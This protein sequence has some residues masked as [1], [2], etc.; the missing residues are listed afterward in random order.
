M[1]IL[2]KAIAE[3]NVEPIVD[4]AKQLAD[5]GIVPIPLN[6][7]MP[8][9]KQ[10]QRSDLT[11]PNS[12]PERF[13]GGTNLGAL[14]GKP[15]GGL[16]DVDLDWTEAGGL[17]PYLLPDS[18]SFGRDG[19]LRH[20]MFRCPGQDKKLTYD[21]PA[22]LCPSGRRIVELL[23]TGQQVMCP[24]SVHPN[25][26][27]LQWHN[28]PE[29]QMLVEITSQELS[30]RM[31]WLAG[32]AL[33][34]RRWPE[35]EGSRHDLILALAGACHSAGWA[36]ADIVLVL[37]AMLAGAQ[38]TEHKDRMRAIED[39]LAKAGKGEQI[40]G[41]PTAA[42]IL[43]QPIADC[44]NKWWRLGESKVVT[45]TKYG[46][47]LAHQDDEWGQ[48]DPWPDLHPFDS[49]AD[50]EPN[51]Y[52]LNA[53]G[54]VLGPAAQDL[55]TREGT[56]QSIAAQ[57]VLA[58]TATLVQPRWNV[59]ADGQ[60]TPTSLFLLGLAGS[61]SGKTA[62]DREAFDKIRRREERDEAEYR[63]GKTTR[64]PVHV[65]T[66]ISIEGMLRML[67]Q[68]SPHCILLHSDA[69]VFFGGYA[70]RD[71]RALQTAGQLAD[72]WSGSPV[73]KI[74]G[75]MDEAIRLSNR[76]LSMSLTIQP[77]LAPGLVLNK[78][79]QAQG[80]L[81]RC[82][83]AFPEPTAI[84]PYSSKV[85]S[86]AWDAFQDQIVRI[87]DIPVDL[88]DV[89][90]SIIF[91]TLSLDNDAFVLW[92]D[93]HERYRKLANGT[94]GTLKPQYLRGAEQVKRLAGN[95]AAIE[96]C[97]SV[98]SDHVA[99]AAELVAFYIREWEWLDAKM[100]AYGDHASEAQQLWDWMRAQPQT[101]FNL[102][103]MYQRG[104]RII[105]GNPNRA[106]EIIGE[107]RERGFV[108][109]SGRDYERRPDDA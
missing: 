16:V 54:P 53:L 49:W 2:S 80:F 17:A 20:V 88:D 48:D 59:S 46:Q 41:W 26:Q 62:V 24:P 76:R 22:S 37:S 97:P 14:L 74:R 89:S 23:A 64:Q 107:L 15:S 56:P 25:G 70:M 19:M 90:G 96:G 50:I 101:V 73:T 8:R 36:Q 61:G 47:P 57:A 100:R 3:S 81:P 5:H 1:N 71:N 108:R 40:T 66:D 102:R 12:L 105:R 94:K 51:E 75:N 42:E 30:R 104:P 7:K 98:G 87:L 86:P 43:G 67:H 95:L 83:V 27:R 106:R 77:D 63:D 34:V 92:R 28:A 68:Q 84:P 109:P 82:L 44:L 29:Q 65:F 6:G 33:L 103:N 69:A 91:K 31:G 60:Q 79:L 32:A 9:E 35:F 11:N 45:L 72:L 21:A 55:A 52:P 93:C 99:N 78:Q 39:T 85:P 38:D 4:A 13:K 18:W 10:W 58:A